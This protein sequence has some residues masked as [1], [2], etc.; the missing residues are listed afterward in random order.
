MKKIN[1]I[2]TFLLVFTLVLSTTTN[3]ETI[4]RGINKKTIINTACN[5]VHLENCEGEH[6][7][8]KP[9]EIKLIAKNY[10]LPNSTQIAEIRYMPIIPKEEIQHSGKTRP[11][12]VFY[13]F[14]A[15]T[16]YYIKKKSNIESCGNLIRSS[17]YRYPG[18]SMKVSTS[19]TRTYSASI[20]SGLSV[21]TDAIRAT[22]S[23][24]YGISFSKKDSVSDKQIV[25]VRK[26]HKR[27]VR[28][29]VNKITYSGELWKKWLRKGDRIRTKCG[30]TKVSR[31]VGVIFV[32]GKNKKCK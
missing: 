28:A 1:R 31:G 13:K 10:G 2:T 22:L 21:S 20:K 16:S 32:I 8:N 25:H 4:K 23:S 5:V 6:I 12:A 30:T 26:H 11:K 15:S 24:A 17:E 14:P 3:A 9:E 19:V 27:K 29:Y 18:G 7:F